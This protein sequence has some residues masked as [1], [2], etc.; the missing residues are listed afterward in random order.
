MSLLDNANVSAN[1]LLVQTDMSIHISSIV[2]Q[3]TCI[4][5]VQD[6]YAEQLR[7]ALKR[8]TTHSYSLDIDNEAK[9]VISENN[10][11]VYFDMY[12]QDELVPISTS[13]DGNCLFNAASISLVQNESLNC[14]LRLLVAIELY[15][16][17]D[18]YEKVLSDIY[19]SV[20]VDVGNRFPS[21]LDFFVNALDFKSGDILDDVNKIVVAI[22][23]QAINICTKNISASDMYYVLLL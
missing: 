10:L 4:K 12:Y 22:K 14:I 7:K 19:D 6:R 18:H 8:K 20:S 11:S 16:C 9:S 13:G 17:A 15:F 2:K 23:L 1:L 5:K 3:P 21:K